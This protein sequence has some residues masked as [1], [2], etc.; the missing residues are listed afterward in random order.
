MWI[1]KQLK[2]LQ[3]VIILSISIWSLGFH[4]SLPYFVWRYHGN[5][6]TSHTAQTG[7][8]TRRRI[9]FPV[10]TVS[11]EHKGVHGDSERVY[12]LTCQAVAPGVFFLQSASG[13]KRSRQRYV[14]GS[15]GGESSCSLRLWSQNGVWFSSQLGF[16]PSVIIPT[17]GQQPVTGYQGVSDRRG[18]EH[19]QCHVGLGGGQPGQAA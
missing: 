8:H 6:S 5:D 4:F 16:N 13:G 15:Y 1:V 9:L 14:S 2:I 17:A 18:L 3:A 10:R 7:P 12:R 19:R 11:C